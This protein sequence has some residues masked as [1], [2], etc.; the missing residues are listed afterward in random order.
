MGR[1]IHLKQNLSRISSSKF[2]RYRP[3]TVL[4]SLS[5]FLLLFCSLLG[6]AHF[7]YAFNGN[8]TCPAETETT[9][10]L[11]WPQSGFMGFT[12][13]NLFISYTGSNGPWTEITA[14]HT[15]DVTKTSY[16]VTGLSSNTNYWFYVVEH[17]VLGQSGQSNTLQVTTA[18]D[19]QLDPIT[20]YDYSS[21]TLTWTDSN[22]YSSLEPFV[23][24]TLQMSSSSSS[25]PWSTVTSLTDS[26]QNSFR[27]MGLFHQ[28]YWFQ[29][30]DTVGPSGNT[31]SSYSNV[32][33]V[34]IPP[35]FELNINASLTK[36]DVSQQDQFS[37]SAT[38]GLPP[39][40]N[41]QW[42]LNGTPITGATSSSYLWTPN[43]AGTYNVYATA[44]DTLHIPID[45]NTIPIQVNSLPFINI[46][47]STYALNVTQQAQLSSSYGGGASPYSFQWYLNGNP[48]S[49]A[50]SSSY[51]WTPTDAGTYS[52]YATVQDSY[53]VTAS[54]TS[55]QVTVHAQLAINISTS[56][57]A[58][59]VGQLAQLSA[60]VTGGNAPY[61]NYQWY[62]N[63]NPIE[64][65][66]SAS[67]TFTPTDEG[68]YN[69]YATA[70]D[71]S[72]TTAS[73]NSVS[74][75]VTPKPSSSSFPLVPIVIVALVIIII[76]IIAGALVLRSRNRNRTQKHEQETQ[77]TPSD[78]QPKT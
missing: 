65:A 26:T 2:P 31:Q 6:S 3:L 56:T 30:Y 63:G 74:V 67:Y 49:G 71:N 8:L 61:S 35:P 21:A 40:S 29:L 36:L 66:T 51:L 15:T 70:Q 11:Q 28:Q 60:T 41:Y 12:G 47:T 45:S 48:I 27:Q 18:S 4:A 53:N 13:Y 39:Y 25:G 16:G 37:S 75:S 19:P 42:Y 58:L 50:T 5:L 38:G 34:T 57:Y 32:V 43:K 73:S 22:T 17:G 1:L 62:L 68:T 64:G 46:S 33:E 23:S 52:I 7:A 54:S 20:T 77:G 76:A 78:D 55:V 10:T 59:E 14:A 69:I 72:N 44:Q 24:Y 9:A